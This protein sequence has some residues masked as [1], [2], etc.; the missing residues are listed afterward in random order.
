[1]ILRKQKQFSVTEE[2]SVFLEDTL[3]VTVETGFSSRNLIVLMKK[4][5]LVFVQNSWP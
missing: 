2:V 1:M 5:A 3:H 4:S